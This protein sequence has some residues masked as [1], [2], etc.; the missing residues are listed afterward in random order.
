MKFNSLI[1]KDV[2]CAKYNLF[3][4][5]LRKLNTVSDYL[6][7]LVIDHDRQDQLDMQ[8]APKDEA[9][10]YQIDPDHSGVDILIN[11]MKKRHMRKQLRKK[12]SVKKIGNPEE[13]G[14][15]LVPSFLNNS[16]L[17]LAKVDVKN[18]I[19]TL[20]KK[21]ISDG[22]ER[23]T[24]KKEIER[25]EREYPYNEPIARSGCF[26]RYAGWPIGTYYCFQSGGFW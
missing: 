18:E 13:D 2:L 4:R 17:A 24:S 5:D 16:S 3:S 23:K 7:Q 26:S 25:P 8:A 6:G 15:A 22:D 20:A 11:A 14:N 21:W 10:E 1:N 19:Q 12:K 9:G